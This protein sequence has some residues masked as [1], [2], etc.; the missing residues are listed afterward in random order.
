MLT[1]VELKMFKCL[2]DMESSR[3]KSSIC[4]IGAPER[5][6]WKNKG[7]AICKEKKAEHFPETIYNLCISYGK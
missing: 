1:I 2:W 5:D 3:R 6:H 4:V 7:E